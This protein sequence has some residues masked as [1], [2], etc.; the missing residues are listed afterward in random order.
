MFEILK[1][2]PGL[3]KVLVTIIKELYLCLKEVA[4]RVTFS[5][6]MVLRNRAQ[7][8]M[9][10]V[11]NNS[12]FETLSHHNTVRCKRGTGPA[13][14]S[15][16]TLTLEFLDSR[17]SQDVL[18]F[19]KIDLIFSLRINSI[20]KSITDGLQTQIFRIRNSLWEPYIRKHTSPKKFC[21]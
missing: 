16:T 20:H 15:R 10:A 5:R 8:A 14:A 17:R 11:I 2:I 19:I 1:L 9:T 6:C 18:I 4:V 3:N 13:R 7:I 21:L 12:V